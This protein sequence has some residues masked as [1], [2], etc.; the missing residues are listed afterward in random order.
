MARGIWA[1][2]RVSTTKGEQELSLDEQ[3]RWAKKHAAAADE[4]VTII[5]ER[6]SAKTTIGR[7]EFQRMIATLQELPTSRRPQQLAVTSL[8]RLSRDMT[9]TLLVA[10]T[11]RSLK[12]DLYVRD[13]GIIKAET[14]AQRAA[15]VGQS[16]GGEA[17]NEARSNRARASWERRRLEGKPASN[18]SPYGLQLESERDV[19]AAKSSDW[20]RKAFEWYTKGI[21]LHTI[22]I[23]F[24]EGAPAHIVRTPRLGNDGK[25]IYRSRNHVWE[26]N[27]IKKLLVQRRY[28][29]TIVEPE[30]F[31]KVQHL[32]ETKP[33]WRQTR[34]GEYPL[35][36][37]VKCA[38]CGRSFHG[39]SSSAIIRKPLASGE[40]AEY[41]A[42]R[43][44]Y[45]ECRVC[46][47]AI[48]A[49]RMEGWFRDQVGILT[50]DERLLKRWVAGE[51]TAD[52]AK[53]TRREIA[54]LERSTAPAAVDAT[55]SRV[56]DLAMGG[57]HAAADLE[58]QLKRLAEKTE[59]DRARLA[60]LR[61]RVDAAESRSRNFDQAKRL[62]ANFWPLYDRAPY[63][64]KRE[65]MGALTAALGGCVA[66]K[67]GLVW[68]RHPGKQSAA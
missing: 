40:I 61:S 66:T 6:A 31:D 36:G 5:K 53:V 56:W 65:L 16:M 34:K 12:V 44:R 46:L 13:A 9:D 26:S 60:E 55:R 24:M 59:A 1:Y 23:R 30:L 11:L 39:R 50:V 37:A 18:K 27:R 54:A 41:K 3:E 25:P 29:G 57:S 43:I 64:Q 28:R 49:E 45:Y 52:D 2:C 51:R 10:R 15:L 47:I 19:P 68:P 33:R 38:T 32:L 20:V 58:R 17:E 14:F 21:G 62:L 35:S 22:A 42:K 7:P 63:E 4:T 67:S 48:N 8:D